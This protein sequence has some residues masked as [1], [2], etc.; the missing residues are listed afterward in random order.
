MLAATMALLSDAQIA[1]HLQGAEWRRDGPA[2][3]RERKFAD[4]ASA[5]AFVDRVA[6]AAEAANHHPDI[7]VH[8]W[9][10]VRLTLSTHSEG[11]LTEADFAL[12][13]SLDELS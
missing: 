7:L 1:Q 10:N 9:N 8:G 3:V 2:I 6:E 5:I 11:G 4:F 13:A 12:A